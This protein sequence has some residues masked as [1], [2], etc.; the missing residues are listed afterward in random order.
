MARH[1]QAAPLRREPSDFETMNGHTSGSD[2]KNANGI[3]ADG[4]LM[5]SAAAVVNDAARRPPK[6]QPQEQAGL[7][8]LII[9]VGGIYVSL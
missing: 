9:C 2:N 8:Q 5:D 4:T 3:L 1:K 6:S 7:T